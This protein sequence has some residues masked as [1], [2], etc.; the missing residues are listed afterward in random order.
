[1][2]CS[3]TSSACGSSP[4]SRCGPR[5]RARRCRRGRRRPASRMNSATR[6][7]SAR[8]ISLR[9]KGKRPERGPLFQSGPTDSTRP[10]RS[11]HS[12]KLKDSIRFIIPFTFKCHSLLTL[13]LLYEYNFGTYS[14]FCARFLHSTLHFGSLS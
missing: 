14:L 9:F 4:A 12:T 2:N 3:A 5:T 6:C 8:S 11:L 1:M 13:V 7:R 10:D